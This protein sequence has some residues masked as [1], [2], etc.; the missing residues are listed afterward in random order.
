MPAYSS[1]VSG[2]PVIGSDGTIYAVFGTKIYAIYG[3]NKVDDIAWPMCRQ[4]RRHTGKVERASL[5]PPEKRTD[6]NFELQLYGQLGGTFTIESSTNLN[7]WT[8]VTGFVATTVPMRIV[9]TNAT[10]APGKFYRALGT[11]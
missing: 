9:V 10:N 5:A 4:N 1:P 2:S 8:S 6:G 3:T 7:T 11:P